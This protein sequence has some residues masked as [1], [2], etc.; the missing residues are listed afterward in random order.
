[1][2]Y[3]FKQ[4][5]TV[6]NNPTITANVDTIKLNPT[7]ETI[8]VTITLTATDSELYGVELTDIKVSN[9]NYEGYE[10]LMEVVMNNLKQYEVK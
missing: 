5:N 2:K 8:S 4:F 10:N 7:N 3:L 6:I 9:L 1:M